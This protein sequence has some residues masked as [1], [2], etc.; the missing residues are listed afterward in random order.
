MAPGP[1]LSIYLFLITAFFSFLYL[2]RSGLDLGSHSNLFHRVDSGLQ[3]VA[4]FLAWLI[5]PRAAVQVPSMG[6]SWFVGNGK[7]VVLCWVWG[8][9][10]SS[11]PGDITFR[12]KAVL[13]SSSRAGMRGI[14]WDFTATGKGGCTQLPWVREGLRFVGVGGFLFIFFLTLGKSSCLLVP[15]EW[16]QQHGG[17]QLLQVEV[18]VLNI[19]DQ[20]RVGSL[21]SQLWDLLNS[22]FNQELLWRLNRDVFPSAGGWIFWGRAHFSHPSAWI[23]P[24]YLHWGVSSP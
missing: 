19:R 17:T 4:T 3:H 9:G 21:L 8:W 14:K 1:D 20:N 24:P 16:S 5:S 12:Q 2:Y 10:S 6:E 13:L 15:R 23:H 7:G 11:V 22:I 18:F